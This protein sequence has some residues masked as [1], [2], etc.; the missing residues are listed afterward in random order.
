M[1]NTKKNQNNIIT[2]YGIHAVTALL[3][4]TPE[5]IIELFI[6][7]HR[8]DVKFREIIHLA[9]SHS[10]SIQFTSDLEK[11]TQGVLAKCYDTLDKKT[12]FPELKELLKSHHETSTPLL[13][14][15]LDNI[16]DP[17]NLGACIRTA[18]AVGAH[19]VI[20]PSDKS[21]SLTPTVRKVAVGAVELTPIYTVTNLS[22]TISDLKEFGVWIY[23]MDGTASKSLYEENFKHS[24]A[25]VMGSEGEGL[26][27]LTKE[28]C[29]SLLS[30]PMK[31]QVESL[32]VSVAAGVC[33]FEALRQRVT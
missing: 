11:H 25:F 31:G 2:L 12:S 30:I 29:D 32:N 1:S 20:I 26:R 28:Q 8:K 16:Q 18:N 9:K 24:T 4:H 6:N 19:A 22:R 21:A 10:I 33:L 15:I 3:K 14:L 17:H 27:R 13:L 23:G 5:K 7:A